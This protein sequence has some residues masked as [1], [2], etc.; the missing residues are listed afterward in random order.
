MSIEHIAD[1]ETRGPEQLVER[2][3]QPRIMAV[4]RSWL[5]ELQYVEDVFWS[6]LTERIVDNA[7]DARLDILGRILGQP[8]EGRSDEVYRAWVAARV[9]VLRS[10]GQ[11]E[12]LIAIMRRL[13]GP[14]V[15][16]YIEEYYPLA[17]MLRAE[18][19]ID[20]TLGAQIA[21]FLAAAKGGG[22]ALHF[23]WSSALSFRL[24]ITLG[25][26]PEFDSPMGLDRSVLAAVSNGN[27]VQFTADGDMLEG[28][29]LADNDGQPLVFDADDD[30]L[31]IG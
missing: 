27:E 30:L 13:L 25:D 24:P 2:Y 9:L 5:S 6:L 28:G 11:I 14:S 29:L 7:S 31:I 22:V 26:E 21:K 19:P 1:Y 12:Q 17:M 8:R 16:I 23:E 10:S 3:R 18:A 15:P 4:L 20:P